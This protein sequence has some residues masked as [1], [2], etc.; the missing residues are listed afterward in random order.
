LIIYNVRQNI[1]KSPG[2]SV[3]TILSTFDFK[4]SFTKNIAKAETE[5]SIVQHIVF[6]ILSKN[7]CYL[8]IMKDYKQMRDVSNIVENGRPLINS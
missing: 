7:K 8:K 4:K 2:F 1:K 5:A 6:Y 3:F